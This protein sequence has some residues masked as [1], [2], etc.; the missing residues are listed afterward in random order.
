MAQVLPLSALGSWKGRRFPWQGSRGQSQCQKS[1]EPR[2]GMFRHLGR[3]AL[4]TFS[5]HKAR[6]ACQAD[7]R[8]LQWFGNLV[9]VAW[10]NDLWLNEGFA[11]YV[12]YLG[13]D[14]AEPT[15]NLVSQLCRGP[16]VWDPGR[17]G[18]RRGSPLPGQ[19][20]EGCR[21]FA[22]RPHSAERGVPCDGRGRAG[23]LPPAVLPCRGCQHAGPDQRDVRLHLL[24]QGAAP[25]SVLILKQ[26]GSWGGTWGL[27]PKGP[28]CS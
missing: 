1:P 15:W 17:G 22:E 20:T 3:V 6:V 8:P 21:G 14:Y 12:E 28:H 4:R 26:R 25:S 16:G 18:G 19:S 2:S 24:Q 11:S 9:T 13:A 23:L 10:W 7:P 27:G 5:D